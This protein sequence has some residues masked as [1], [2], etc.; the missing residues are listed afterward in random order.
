[1]TDGTASTHTFHFYRGRVALYALLQACH[2]R[3]GDEV[4]HQAF[5]CL[6]VPSPIVA[7]GL[8]PVY[9]DVDPKTY[10]LDPE[11]LESRITPRA[12]VL[13]VQHTFGIPAPMDRIMAAA[14]R[15]GLIVIEDCCHTL[16]SFY[17]GQRLGSIGDGAFYSYEWGKP[18][19]IGI[20]GAATTRSE[21]LA[22]SLRTLYSGFVE[23]PWRDTLTIQAQYFAHQTLRRPAFFWKI[24][25]IYHRLSDSGIAVGTYAAEEL[26]GDVDGEYR[27]RM[28]VP[29][30]ARL[31]RKLTRAES[32][33]A[34]RKSLGAQYDE[35]MKQLGVDRPQPPGGSE[36]VYLRY[37]LLVREKKR[38]LDEAQAWKVELGDWYGSPVHPL[39]ETDW[40]RVGYE[41]GCCPIA[42]D[43]CKRVVTLPL[44]ERLR[45]SDI[46]RLLSFW[47]HVRHRGWIDRG[48]MGA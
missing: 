27:R 21:A 40:K 23:P 5:T 37:P 12:R 35:S 46:E 42:E 32:N 19:I 1:M 30:Q 22:A 20:G 43:I 47:E 16:G 48:Q 17:Q 45:A 7:L 15:H 14:R 41:K 31:R 13:V 4:L 9:V 24:R 29:F 11:S 10:N 3:P 34:L 44:Y 39:T 25:E 18:I 28:A 6:A 38:V 8:R 36:T 2:L 26:S 33:I